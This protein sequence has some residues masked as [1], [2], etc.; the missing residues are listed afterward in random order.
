MPALLGNLLRFG[1]LLRGAGINIHHGRLLD[2]AEALGHVDLGA[3]E[4]VYHACRALLVHRQEQFATFDLA[5]AAFWRAQHGGGG[6][7]SPPSAA[8]RSAIEIDAV[9]LPDDVAP[10][11]DAGSAG[12]PAAITFRT[13]SDVE[14]LAD[15]DFAALT[16][17]ELAA[18]TAALSRLTWSP[19]LRRTRRW[20]RGRG[21]SVDLRRTIA[22]SLRTGGDVAS[23][24]R[25]TRR[26]RPRGLVLLCDVSG[27][28][29]RYSR[30]LLHFAHAVATRHHDVEAFLF[31]T[32]L[33][34]V[35]QQLRASRTNDAV[36]A[37]SRAVHDWSG[38]TRIGTAVKTFHTH[39][40]RRA[41]RRNP[42]VLLI[43]DGWDRGDT[44]ELRDAIARLQRNC[45]R[46]VWL[47]PLAGTA[48][49]APLTRG[50]Q[51]ALPFVDDFLP[52]RT[53]NDLADVAMHLN[54][55]A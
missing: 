19:G 20:I 54:A 47:C 17:A 53:L 43:S 33:T 49:Y 21:G 48:G 51:A 52:A 11:A 3:R 24:A 1:R 36:A 6:A 35:T 12:E 7:V 22:D 50:L 34:R 29:E 26:K 4:D 55:L 45:H 23:L 5:F 25:R 32:G 31:S 13:W 39:W 15:K 18:A 42:V 37:V 27:S 40:G 46:L 9:V 10:G 14:R 38:G 44:A 8:P 30:V 41:L 28:M 16:D 2:V